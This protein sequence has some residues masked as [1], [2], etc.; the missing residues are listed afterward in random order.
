MR[1]RLL[2]AM[3]CS[4]NGLLSKTA[5]DNPFICHARSVLLSAAFENVP[6]ARHYKWKASGFSSASSYSAVWSCIKAG[7]RVKQRLVV[8]SDFMIMSTCV[9]ASICLCTDTT[10]RTLQT[11]RKVHRPIRIGQR[12]RSPGGGRAHRDNEAP[13]K[14]LRPVGARDP[15][16]R[17]AR[18]DNHLLCLQAIMGS[19]S[20]SRHA[21]NTEEAHPT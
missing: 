21:V 7:L 9:C 6:P 18:R 14:R 11:P 20:C 12:G 15:Q 8:R 10:A 13:S 5:L 4:G 1:S 2:C 17:C 16:T 19:A 3:G